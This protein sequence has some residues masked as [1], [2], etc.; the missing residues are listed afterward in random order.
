MNLPNIFVYILQFLNLHI[1]E[2]NYGAF[3]SVKLKAALSW[4]VKGQGASLVSISGLFT[5]Q[6]EMSLGWFP[7]AQTNDWLVWTSKT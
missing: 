4:L 7:V 5:C 1:I 3:G 2:K 6:I